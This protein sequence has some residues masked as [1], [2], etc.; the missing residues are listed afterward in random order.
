M[1]SLTGWAGGVP[2]RPEA[3]GGAHRGLGHVLQGQFHEGLLPGLLQGVAGPDDGLQNVE[4]PE[5]VPVGD[6]WAAEWTQ[7]QGQVGSRQ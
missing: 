1:G 6:L 7:A 2:D 4:Q 5:L 3:G